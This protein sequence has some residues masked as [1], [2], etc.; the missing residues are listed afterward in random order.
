M[1]RRDQINAAIILR[2]SSTIKDDS[3]HQFEDKFIMAVIH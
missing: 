1:F 2:S 3:A